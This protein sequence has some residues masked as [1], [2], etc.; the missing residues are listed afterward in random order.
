[1]SLSWKDFVYFCSLKVSGHLWINK[2]IVK[3]VNLGMAF[4]AWPQK[5]DI[6]NMYKYLYCHGY[7]N[8]QQEFL[9]SVVVMQGD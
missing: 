3:Y 8:I 5:E 6:L 1:M 4:V 9:N 7:K 2:Y